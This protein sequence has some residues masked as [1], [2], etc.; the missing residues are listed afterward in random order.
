[1][2]EHIP[3]V[4]LHRLVI[5]TWSFRK[6]YV[7]AVPA[8]A[9]LTSWPEAGPMVSLSASWPVARWRRPLTCWDELSVDG[10]S[11]THRK[12]PVGNAVDITRARRRRVSRKLPLLSRHIRTHRR[13]ALMPL[14]E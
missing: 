14:E 8:M 4:K 1:M 10:M 12:M 11:S 3:Q 2:M 5:R 13:S 9:E 7:A 6:L